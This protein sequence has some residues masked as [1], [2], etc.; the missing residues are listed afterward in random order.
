MMRRIVIQHRTSKRFLAPLPSPESTG[1][2]E[3]KEPVNAAHYVTEELAEGDRALLGEFKDAYAV[4][5]VEIG[6]VR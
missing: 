2:H 5:T 4:V 6:G 1:I 3:V